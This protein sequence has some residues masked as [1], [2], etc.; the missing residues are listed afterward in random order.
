[1][2]FFALSKK[3][4]TGPS[5][6]TR[7]KRAPFTPQ[8]AR[9]D[10]LSL[11]VKGKRSRLSPLPPRHLKKKGG[12]PPKHQTK[13]SG[14]VEQKNKSSTSCSNTTRDVP[15]TYF[16]QKRRAPVYKNF[17][18]SFDLF[19]IRSQSSLKRTEGSPLLIKTRQSSS[20][21]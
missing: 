19:I 2:S 18:D 1:M 11:L 14:P 8:S 12:T 21:P 15:P 6:F 13:K 16:W 20:S 3:R 9:R 7:N 5:N 4:Q 17:F 10:L